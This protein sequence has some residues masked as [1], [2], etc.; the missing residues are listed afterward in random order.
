MD[1]AENRQSLF[2]SSS[3]LRIWSRTEY[4]LLIIVSLYVGSAWLI[5]RSYGHPGAFH[6]LLYVP[7][8]E[9]AFVVILITYLVTRILWIMIWWH[10]YYLVRTLLNDFSQTLFNPQRLLTA[11]PLAAMFFVF[12]GAF[13]SMKSMIPIIHPFAWDHT[14]AELD[15]LLHGG[16]HPWQLLHGLLGYPWITTVVNFFYNFWFFLLIFIFFWQAFTSHFPRLRLQ[17]LLSFFLSWIVIGH[18]SATFFSSAGPCYYGAIIR[19]GQENPYTDLLTYLQQ[20]NEVSPVWV[21]DTQATLWH[22]YEENKLMPG[23]GI[24][25]MP[26]MHVAMAALFAFL[27]FQLGKPHNFLFTM[28]L[29][30]I[31][32]G[33]VHLA[34]HYAVDAY[35]AI[36]LTYGIWRFSGL[37]V[38]RL[39]ATG[40]ASSKPNTGVNIQNSIPAVRNVFLSSG[41][42]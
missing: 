13:S 30:M 19:E 3:L 17:F 37:V 38:R 29:I 11:L 15:K 23:S 39:E 18:I 32:L 33:S 21:L 22:S 5:T 14:F 12:F 7:V 31:V 10:P 42:R 25:A 2:L 27:A 24:S 6:G 35:V 16:V 26:S 4:L 40:D 9:L 36:L 28:Y 8:P 34:W 1:V 20:A 41:T